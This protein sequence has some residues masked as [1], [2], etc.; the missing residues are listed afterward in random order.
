MKSLHVLAEVKDN[1]FIAVIRTNNKQ[2]FINVARVLLDNGLKTIEVTLTTPNATEIIK[3]LSHEY[4]DAIIGA[5]TV[6][7]KAS[8]Q[9]SIEAGARFIVSPGFDK[10]SAQFANTYDIPYIPGCMTVTEMIHAS[11]FGCNIIKLFPASQFNSKAIQDFKGPL[12]QLEFIPTG[13]IGINNSEEWLAAG[14]YAV[15]I[16]SEITKIYDE[17]GASELE[18]YIKKLMS[19]NKI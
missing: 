4:Q 19:H 16:G 10:A 1:R 14:S 18:K 8:A 9:A 6:L 13:G 3:E 2:K 7:D 17:A 12:P 5:G 15:G 11:R